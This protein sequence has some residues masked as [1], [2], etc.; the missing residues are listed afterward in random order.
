MC[1]HLMGTHLENNMAQ[2]FIMVVII[3]LFV[4]F[5]WTRFG[6]N[7]IEFL[8][9]EPKP[10]TKKDALKKKI[11]ALK[12]A[13]KDIENNSKELEATKKLKKLYDQLNE[14]EEELKRLNRSL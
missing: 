12:Q 7:L 3:G 6:D 13:A 5:V 4:W 8:A 11:A 9:N 10:E 14:D 2:L 1:P